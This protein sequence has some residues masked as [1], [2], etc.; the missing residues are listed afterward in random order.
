MVNAHFRPSDKTIELIN[1]LVKDYTKGLICIEKYLS[2]RNILC[3]IIAKESGIEYPDENDISG[4]IPAFNYHANK[5]F[6]KYITE[7]YKKE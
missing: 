7:K 1:S 6:D 5:S 4:C 2:E 3:K